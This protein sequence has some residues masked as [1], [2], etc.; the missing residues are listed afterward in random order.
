[1]NTVLRIAHLPSFDNDSH[2]RPHKNH[3]A[4]VLIIVDEIKKND[5]LN[6]DIR[7]DLVWS[8]FPKK[9]GTEKRSSRH[10]VLER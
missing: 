4:G 3:P 5:Q 8:Q 6:E 10:T 2:T 9:C 1:M 7:N